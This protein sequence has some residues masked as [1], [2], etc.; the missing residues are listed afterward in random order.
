MEHKRR[1]GILKDAGL[2]GR[3]LAIRHAFIEFITAALVPRMPGFPADVMLVVTV[4]YEP[5][6]FDV[7]RFALHER[8]APAVKPQTRTSGPAFQPTDGVL[9]S[10]LGS[11]EVFWRPG[12]VGFGD[13]DPK[14]GRSVVSDWTMAVRRRAADPASALMERVFE[15][16]FGTMT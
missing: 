4:N 10:A 16:R 1:Y 12:G 14:S 11:V 8:P 5:E 7:P 6:T 3:F 15:M 2:L 13:Y 9:R